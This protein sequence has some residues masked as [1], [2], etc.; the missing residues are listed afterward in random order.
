[1]VS[2]VSFIIYFATNNKDHLFFYFQESANQP[3]LSPQLSV[4]D[5]ESKCTIV[6]AALYA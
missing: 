6:Y 1:M 5:D 4:Q 3:I 2:G